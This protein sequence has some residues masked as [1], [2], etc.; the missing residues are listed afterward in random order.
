MSKLKWWVRP[1]WQS[2]KP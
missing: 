1:V 2:E